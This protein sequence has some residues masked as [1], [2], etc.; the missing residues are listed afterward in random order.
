MV[1]DNKL[2]GAYFSLYKGVVLKVCKSAY[3]FLFKMEMLKL[4]IK[5]SFIHVEWVLWLTWVYFRV[6]TKK[7]TMD[8]LNSKKI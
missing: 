3:M 5:F 2:P 1:S 8:D 4:S 7:T 6:S